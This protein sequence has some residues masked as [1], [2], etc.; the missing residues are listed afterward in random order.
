[1]NRIAGPFKQE[2]FSHFR[3]S[4]LG[5]VERKM[6]GKF[7]LIHHLSFPPGDSIN[8]G[9]SP[10]DAHVQYQSI[11][12]AAQ[13]LQQLGQ[14]LFWSKTDIADAFRI[15]PL[16]PSQYRLFGFVW[17]EQFYYDRCLPLG[18]SAS[19]KIFETRSNALQWIASSKLHIRNI[20]HVLD[21]FLLLAR[22]K[23]VGQA[24]LSSFLSMCADIGIPIAPDKTVQP[25]QLISFLD[26][27]L[28]SV[29][30]EA[31]LPVDKLNKCTALIE[32]CLKKDKIQLKPLQS[33]NGTLNFACQADS[34]VVS[35]S[36]FLRRLIN[37]TTGVTRPC[38]Y[39]RITHEVREDLKTWLIFLQA[40][41]G[42]SLM[43]PQHWL[44]SHCI[45][46]YTDASGTL[47]YGAVLGLQWLFWRWD[48]EWKGQSVT[49]L[50]F[51]PIVVAVNVWADS[52]SNKCVSFHSDNRAVVDINSQKSKDTNVMHLMRKLVLYCLRHNIL[53][54]AV[55][56]RGINNLADS[57][58]SALKRSRHW[59]Q[60]PV[61]F[62]SASPF[63]QH[64]RADP[65]CRRT[66]GFSFSPRY[67]N[68][69]Q[70][71]LVHVW[72]NSVARMGFPIQSQFQRQCWH[73]LSCIF[74]GQGIRQPLCHHT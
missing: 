12:H 19:C 5:L 45:D 34:Q 2:P 9:I 6:P 73:C 37:L 60:R 52:L 69:V 22:D 38:H 14:G 35:G 48:D 65:A 40:F 61:P 39:I 8:D 32:T 72:K 23:A 11:D 36:P 4:P 10:E 46:L 56:I 41:N 53:F 28:E 44:Q 27:E 71:Q 49:L 7:R 54:R 66:T 59:R 13:Q 55:H 25:S 62:L 63:S 26:I 43:L 17:R 47:A 1:M 20:S 51:Y 57:L 70:T 67:P 58:S 24:Q 29:A 42:K 16:H 21:D 64:C 33:V 50:E 15:V 68:G 3:T 18:C 30:M 74:I 31:R